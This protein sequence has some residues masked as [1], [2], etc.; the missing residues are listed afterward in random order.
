MKPSELMQQCRPQLQHIFQKYPDIQQAYI[1]GS[2]AR[3]D[4][5]EK[6]DLD[7]MLHY[8]KGMNLFVLG[9]LQ[10]DIEQLFPNLK[11]DLINARHYSTTFYPTENQLI[12]ERPN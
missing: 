3:G 11:I 10:D 5:T 1:F 8:P 4:D 6:S 12:Y 7:I 9:G 2:V